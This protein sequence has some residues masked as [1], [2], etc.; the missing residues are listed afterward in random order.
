MTLAPA[1]TTGADAVCEMLRSAGADTVTELVAALLPLVLSKVVE[2]TLAVAEIVEPSVTPAFTV[3]TT[4]KAAVPALARF[5][6][7]VQVIVPVAPTA[8]L[9]Q[10]QPAAGVTEEKVVLVGV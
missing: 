8:G 6:P 7:S 3:T 2:V 1:A 9:V 10:V 5:D 4:V